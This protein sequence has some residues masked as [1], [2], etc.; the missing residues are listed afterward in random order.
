MEPLRGSDVHSNI[1]PPFWKEVYSKRKEFAPLIEKNNFQK[2]IYVQ[3]SKQE[4]TKVVSL[5]IKCIQS[6]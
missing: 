5:V 3:E 1:L 2:G 4:V 6:P